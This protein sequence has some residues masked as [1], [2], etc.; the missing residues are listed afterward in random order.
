MVIE[1]DTCAVQLLLAF[2]AEVWS[3]ISISLSVTL[4]LYCVGYFWRI[5]GKDG[6]IDKHEQGSN[7]VLW[8]IKIYIYATK[9]DSYK[10]TPTFCDIFYEIKIL[11]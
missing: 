2:T 11:G 9:R 4:T 7:A 6:K 1:G 10:N 8:K 5:R 3:A